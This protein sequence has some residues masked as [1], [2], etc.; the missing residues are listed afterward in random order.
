[1]KRT[2]GLCASFLK[3][4]GHQGFFF[5]VKG[6]LEHQGHQG[7]GGLREVSGL[8]LWAL[9][10]E[11]NPTKHI[12]SAACKKHAASD[13]AFMMNVSKGYMIS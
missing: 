8:S 11:K 6:T 1:M 9:Q 4:K 5:L 2:K 13:R 7:N 12:T 10:L 3:G